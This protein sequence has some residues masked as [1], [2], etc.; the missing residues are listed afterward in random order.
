MKLVV[1]TEFQLLKVKNTTFGLIFHIFGPNSPFWPKLPIL[2]DFRGEKIKNQHMGAYRHINMFCR[3]ECHPE[4][5]SARLE[6]EKIPFK[7][8]NWGEKFPF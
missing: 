5:D 8:S 7:C 3:A 6:I 2:A 4:I 1:W